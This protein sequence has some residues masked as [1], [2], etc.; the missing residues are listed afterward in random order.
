LVAAEVA[1]HDDA[2]ASP[3]SDLVFLALIALPMD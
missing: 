3:I 1:Q 2:E